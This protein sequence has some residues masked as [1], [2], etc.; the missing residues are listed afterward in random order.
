MATT[1]SLKQGE[2]RTNHGPIPHPLMLPWE[3]PY[4]VVKVLSDVTYRIQKTSRSK[5][6]VVHE[7]RLKPYE[8]PELKAWSYVV[9]ESVEQVEMTQMSD[10]KNHASKVQELGENEEKGKG[11]SNQSLKSTSDSNSDDTIIENKE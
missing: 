4:Q 3:G 9:P 6:Q 7:D 8:G 5:P 1:F 11:K 10:K 2:T